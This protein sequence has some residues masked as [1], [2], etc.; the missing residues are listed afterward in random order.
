MRKSGGLPVN[1]K[2]INTLV[3]VVKT[4]LIIAIAFVLVSLIIFLVSKDPVNAVYQFFI[5]PFTSLR[6]IGNIVEAATPLVFTGLAV[7]IIFRSGLF[8]LITEGSFFIGVVGAMIAGIA[9]SLPQGVHPA[10]AMA[11]GA[12]FGACAAAI[13]AVLK[14]VWNV[15]ELVTSIMLNYIMQFLAIYLVNYHFREI[16]SSSL[17]SRLLAPSSKLPVIIP[18]TRIH[19]GVLI[20]LLLCVLV[21]IFLF[22]LRLG[23]K[24]RVTGD[25]IGFARYSGINAAAVMVAA[26][27]I[28]G[29]IAGLG[30]GIEMIGL[31]TRFRWTATPGYGW[32]GIVVALLARNN[33]LLI[34]LAAGFIAYMNVGADIMSRSSDMSTEMVLIIQGIMLMLI[35]ADALLQR[36]RQR[37]IVKAASGEQ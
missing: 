15:S 26:Q 20:G 4:G 29:A 33:P 10:A 5:G 8:S 6:R 23:Y 21:W 16:S 11:I 32:V 9:F 1:N 36:W 13:P 27:I 3:D 12:L 37:M 19:L 31:Y 34:P 18:G 25:N 35:A 7:T 30:G 22:R 28:A 17:A 2:R 24:L 14:L